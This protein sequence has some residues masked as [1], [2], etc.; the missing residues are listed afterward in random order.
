MLNFNNILL[1]FLVTS[2][3]LKQEPYRKVEVQKFREKIQMFG[4]FAQ[5]R[6]LDSG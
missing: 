1:T 2:W 5:V 3:T 4:T 6:L